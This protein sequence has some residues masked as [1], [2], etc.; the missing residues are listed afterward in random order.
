M[1][2]EISYAISRFSSETQLK[3]HLPCVSQSS[4]PDHQV[5]IASTV[6]PINQPTNRRVF[7]QGLQWPWRSH[8]LCVLYIAPGQLPDLHNSRDAMVASVATVDGVHQ[9]R[10]R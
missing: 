8:Q 6:I 5:E 3:K 1:W 2:V 7:S 4:L 9:L 10:E